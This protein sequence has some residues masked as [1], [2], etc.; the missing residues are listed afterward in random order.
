MPKLI[1]RWAAPITGL[2]SVLVANQQKCIHTSNKHLIKS[3]KTVIP[4]LERSAYQINVETKIIYGTFDKRPQVVKKKKRR[5][6]IKTNKKNRACSIKE[7]TEK[8]A[9]L[10]D[11][12]VVDIQLEFGMKVGKTDTERGPVMR[13]KDREEVVNRRAVSTK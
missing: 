8:G 1:K 4:L 3:T 11:Q 12:L 5:K 6:A 9:K 2:R 10:P 13:R 7:C